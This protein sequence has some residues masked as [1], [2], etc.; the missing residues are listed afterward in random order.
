MKKADYIVFFKLGITSYH[1][2]SNLKN[3]SKIH[4]FT[5]EM[6]K[7]YSRTELI[8]FADHRLHMHGIQVYYVMFSRT[9]PNKV[10]GEN[11]RIVSLFLFIC[12]RSRVNFALQSRY[13]PPPLL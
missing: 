9:M 3:F 6:I 7:S 5:K 10:C 1:K 8:H 4:Q 2:N 12:R 13:E 11:V